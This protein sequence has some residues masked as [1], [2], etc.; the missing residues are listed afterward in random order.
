MGGDDRE[1][2][3]ERRG[4]L[5]AAAME[6]DVDLDV[7]PH[8]ALQALGECRVFLEP[9]RGVDQP[10]QLLLRYEAAVQTGVELRGRLD[11]HGLPE[12]HLRG[13]E[14]LGDLGE[15]RLVE[16]HHPIG[17]GV[18]EDVPQQ[19]EGRQ[20]LVDDAELLG[21]ADRLAQHL[22]V[23]VEAV[24]IEEQHWPG[25]TL[26]LHHLVQGAE[27]RVVAAAVVARADGVEERRHSRRDD[28]PYAS[29]LHAASK[30]CRRWSFRNFPPGSSRRRTAWNASHCG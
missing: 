7:D 9:L 16:R 28:D 4:V 25:R 1:D 20:R 6:A 13:R 26:P 21:R 24:E 5:H 30:Q 8:A 14:L 12:E 3:V 22:D 27:V 19:R 18:L 17:G 11:R 2:A 15:K 29:E 10:L 23:L